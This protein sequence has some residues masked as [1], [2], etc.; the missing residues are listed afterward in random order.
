MR[1]NQ[2]T[3]ATLRPIP[4]LLLTLLSYVHLYPISSTDPTELPLASFCFPPRALGSALHFSQLTT[5]QRLATSLLPRFPLQKPEKGSA[6]RLPSPHSALS[7]AL[8]PP[9]QLLPPASRFQCP[10]RI[11]RRF[12]PLP[13][14]V[15]GKRASLRPTDHASTTYNKPAAMLPCAKTRK[16]KR[17]SRTKL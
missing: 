11:A 13:F 3:A 15:A 9:V 1:A 17:D 16:G 10:T 4:C 8:F 6:A 5:P 14:G 2:K 7:P 12:P